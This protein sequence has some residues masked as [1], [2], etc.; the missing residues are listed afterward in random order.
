MNTTSSL[1][2]RGLGRL[3]PLLPAVDLMLLVVLFLLIAFAAVTLVIRAHILPIEKVED[4]ETRRLI[5]SRTTVLRLCETAG[6]WSAAGL[7]PEHEMRTLMGLC[8][9]VEQIDPE[10][11][12]TQ[13]ARSAYVLQRLK[14][15]G[16]KAEPLQDIATRLE[17]RYGQVSGEMLRIRATR[18]VLLWQ[19]RAQELCELKETRPV[20]PDLSAIPPLDDPLVFAQAAE[21]YGQDVWDQHVKCV[22]S[23]TETIDEDLLRFRTNTVV[24]EMTPDEEQKAWS[25]IFGWV[26][27]YLPQGFSQIFVEG[28]CDP[29]GTDDRNDQ[30]SLERAQFVADAILKHLTENGNSRALGQ[31]YEVHIHGYAARRRLEPQ[32]GESEPHWYSRLRRIEIA[33]RRKL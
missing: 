23:K 10:S 22:E 7:V 12:Q 6:Q 28:H 11:N 31:G 13:G 33:F 18:Q 8:A 26:D 1:P 14:Q 32:H 16:T 24:P 19:K 4:A 25:R 2:A 9:D 15:I 21:R 27:Q 30:L 17:A 29:T 20:A 3:G 5:A